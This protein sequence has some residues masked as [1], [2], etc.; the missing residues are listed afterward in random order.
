MKL[1]RDWKAFPKELRDGVLCVGNFD[2]VHLGHAEM[3]A[4][5]RKEA[6]A[7]HSSFTI[8]TFD[9][10]PTAILKPNVQR[11]PLT[12]FEQR[13]KLLTA[14]SPDVVMVVP[15]DREF[16][17][18]TA[19]E[20]LK[21]IVRGDESAGIGA[22]LMVEGPTFSFGRGAKGNVEMLTSM[23][24]SLGFDTIIVPTQKQSLTDLTLVKV[25]SSLIRWLVE[26]GRV[27]D[28][29]RALGRPYALRGTVVKGAQRGQ[30]LG[31]PTANLETTQL[32]PG[33]GIY[34][35]QAL[36]DGVPHRAAISIG[37]NPTFGA[38]RITVEAYLLDFTGDLYGKVLEVAF[39]RWVREMYTFAGT[40]PLVAQIRRDVD[41]TRRVIQLKETG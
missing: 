36:V 15:T 20:F 29:A 38:G 26:Q 13:L 2:G 37:N 32:L 35:G 39:V 30:A 17:S 24:G 19:E 21:T 18:I 3:L 25:S 11:F 23:G 7:R 12:T 31:F 9:P 1:L 10:H 33:P 28:A 14:F 22:R 5:G 40:A 6:Q 8:M 16:L 41:V 4:T 34:A 27:A